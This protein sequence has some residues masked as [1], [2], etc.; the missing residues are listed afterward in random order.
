MLKTDRVLFW[1][2]AAWRDVLFSSGLVLLAYWLG[3]PAVT[4]PPNPS[5]VPADSIPDWYL[6]WYFTV[7]ALWPYGITNAMLILVL[8]MAVVALIAVPFIRNRG[9]RH[10][11][12]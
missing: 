11:A 12:R 5:I 8:L 6:T 10:P 9:E 3:P 4:V 7:L 2:T 1:P